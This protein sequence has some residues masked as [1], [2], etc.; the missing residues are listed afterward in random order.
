[1]ADSGVDK[2]RTFWGVC[3]H[4]NVM[5][6]LSAGKVRQTWSAPVK[7]LKASISLSKIA[8]AVAAAASYELLSSKVFHR[9]AI[10]RVVVAETKKISE[11]GRSVTPYKVGPEQTEK[12]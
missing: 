11:K 12:R 1:V 4:K 5:V 10:A 2:M 3:A 8:L 7:C 6:F 9:L